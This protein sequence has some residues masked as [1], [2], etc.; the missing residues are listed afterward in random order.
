MHLDY[1]RN[2]G[3]QVKRHAGYERVLG[4]GEGTKMMAYVE[5]K[6]M[7]STE[8]LLEDNNMVVVR[9]GDVRVGGVYWQPEWRPITIRLAV[10]GLHRSGTDIRK[11]QKDKS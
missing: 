2:G 1:D 6:L 8:V 10:I 9:V 5:S 7:G 3:L 4:L 11:R